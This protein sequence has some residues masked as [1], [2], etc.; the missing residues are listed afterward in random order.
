MVRRRA[1]S[2]LSLLGLLIL[3]STATLAGAEELSLKITEKDPPEEL[4][5]PI[6]NELSN[7]VIELHNDAGPVFEIWLRKQLPASKKAEGGESALTAIEP[8]TLIGA[9]H[10]HEERYDFRDD[11]VDPGVYTMRMAIQ[12]QDGNHLGTAPNDYFAI[13]LRADLDQELDAFPDHDEMV[14]IA[15]EDT[16]AEHPPI[17]NLQPTESTEGE[18]P[19]LEEGDEESESKLVYLKFPAKAGQ[20]SFTLTIG[21]AYSGT[22]DV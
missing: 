9:I 8:I 17:F 14:E 11:P 2:L 16:I 7:T 22:G 3:I 13:L 20:E 1:F 4:A 10:L 5:A 15:S 19:R 18:F 12:P 6:R 21:L